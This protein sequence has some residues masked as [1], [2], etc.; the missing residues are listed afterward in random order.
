MDE[1]RNV[2][3][4]RQDL[5]SNLTE[6]ESIRRLLRRK[7]VQRN[8]IMVMSIFSIAVVGIVMVMVL[9]IKSLFVPDELKGSWALDEVTSYVFD[10]E[11]NGAMLVSESKYRFTYKVKGKT[12]IVDY[13]S[14]ILVDGEYKFKVKKDVLNLIGGEGTSGDTY[15]LTKMK[16]DP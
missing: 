12:L 2:S 14:D 1:K 8:R 16:S 9:T 6:D 11:K 10:G 7:R 13:E 4:N 5:R 15:E 3:S